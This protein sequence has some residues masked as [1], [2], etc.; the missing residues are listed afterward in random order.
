MLQN[1]RPQVRKNR[2]PSPLLKASKQILPWKALL[3]P[4]SGSGKRR[5][6]VLSIVRT[7]AHT[8]TSSAPRT[9]RSSA[10]EKGKA[11]NSNIVITAPMNKFLFERMH[12]SKA[13]LDSRPVYRQEFTRGH[14]RVSR[15]ST[16][17]AERRRADP[18]PSRTGSG[19]YKYECFDRRS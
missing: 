2:N 10:C 14:C 3:A 19:P 4:V 11:I 8:K 13:T 16:I 15:L 5:A 12:K 6:V 18:S 9:L 7:G 1:I 17:F